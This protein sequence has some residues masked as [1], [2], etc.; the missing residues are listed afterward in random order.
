MSQKIFFKNQR[1]V[2]QFN[3]LEASQKGQ[4]HINY[5]GLIILKFGPSYDTGSVLD[6]IVIWDNNVEIKT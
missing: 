2:S 5:K 3:F 4:L 6:Y 1:I